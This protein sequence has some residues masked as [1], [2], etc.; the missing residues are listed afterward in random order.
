MPETTNLPALRAAVDKTKLDA[1]KAASGDDKLILDAMQR[2]AA[3][4]AELAKAEAALTPKIR[5]TRTPKAKP[6]AAAELAASG[7]PKGE[8]PAPDGGKKK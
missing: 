7:G 2:N 4:D 1:I 6:G 5:K 3:L 8:A